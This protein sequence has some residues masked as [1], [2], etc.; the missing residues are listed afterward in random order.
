MNPCWVK[1]LNVQRS[2]V[3]NLFAQGSIWVTDAWFYPNIRQC[4][5]LWDKTKQ[6]NIA[7]VRLELEK[8][9]NGQF[10]VDLEINK[11][12]N[13][14]QQEGLCMIT[15]ISNNISSRSVSAELARKRMCCYS[16]FP[17][18]SN[19]RIASNN[20]RKSLSNYWPCWKHLSTG[21]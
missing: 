21:N 12:I 14:G 19:V 16:R 11:C 3:V 7:N 20:V 8:T 17:K 4:C 15:H 5:A 2:F 13:S 10:M 9:R 6:S 18:W 1:R